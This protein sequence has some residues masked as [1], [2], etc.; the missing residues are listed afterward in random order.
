ML[1]E[2][3]K[4]LALENVHAATLFPGFS[5]VAL[6]LKEQRQWPEG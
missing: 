2:L 3:L 5:G 1:G 4:L 6:H